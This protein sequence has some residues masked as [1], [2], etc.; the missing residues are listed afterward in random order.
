MEK[1]SKKKRHSYTHEFKLKVS[2][3]YMNNG[4]NIART[5][6]MFGI[7]QKQVRTWLKNEEITQQ[8]KHSSKA[9]G[10]GCTTK[11]LIIEDALDAEYKEVRAKGKFFKN[12]DS[13]QEPSS[14]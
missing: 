9:S 4:K 8:Q 7:D 3:C 2:D 13:T 12:V 1:Q 5:A 14:Y 11:Y 6:Q 10:G